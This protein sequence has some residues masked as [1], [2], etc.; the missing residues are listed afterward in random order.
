MSMTLA[1]FGL[2]GATVSTGSMA[3]MQTGGPEAMSRTGFGGFIGTLNQA[4]PT[5]LPVSIGAIVLSLGIR[6]RAAAI[7]ALLAGGIMY[8]G[9]YAQP[10]VSLMYA[11]IVM[12]MIA[13]TALYLWTSRLSRRLLAPRDHP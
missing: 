1:V 3:G 12:G 9:M 2:L 7:A 11:S 6:R 10:R 4:G 8:W 5:I 13:W